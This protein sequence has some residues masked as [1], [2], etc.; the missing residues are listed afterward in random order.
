MAVTVLKWRTK[1]LSY[2]VSC[3]KRFLHAFQC[4]IVFVCNLTVTTARTWTS[5]SQHIMSASSTVFRVSRGLTS[6]G[7]SVWLCQRN[8]LS[9]YCCIVDVDT[10]LWALEDWVHCY[11]IISYVIDCRVTAI[12]HYTAAVKMVLLNRHG[13]VANEND[14]VA[15]CDFTWT[16][17][18]K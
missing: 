5:V 14:F 15:D 3:G 16:L 9:H 7:F 1:Q 10:V 13:W 2:Y 12:C 4:H 6:S 8:E 18:F 11:N 17:C